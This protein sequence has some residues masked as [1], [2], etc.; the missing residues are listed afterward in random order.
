AYLQTQLLIA[1]KEEAG[2]QLQAE[3]YDLMAAAADLDEIKEVNVN[4]IL[5]ANLQQASTSGTQIDSAPV[6]DSN[7]SAEVH[8]NYDD[9]EIF[10]MF[11]QEEQYTELLEPIPESHQVPQNDND[12]IS[13]DTSVEQGSFIVGTIPSPEINFLI[14]TA[15][16]PASEAAMYSASVADITVVLCLELF[17]SIA[18]PFKTKTPVKFT[19]ILL[20]TALFCMNATSGLVNLIAYIMEPT[21]E[22]NGI[23]EIDMSNHVPNVNSIYNVSNK[24]VKH[25][26]DSTYLWHCHLAHISKKRIEKLKHDELLKS[27]D[28]ESF[29][30]CVSCLSSKMT[31]K[32]FPHR[33]ERATDVLGLIHTDVCRLLRLVSGQ[34]AAARIL[35]MVPTKKVDK[36]PYELWFGKVPILSYLKV[37]GCEV[38]VKRDTPDKLQQRSIKCIFIGYLKETMGYYFYFPP[39]NKIVV[40]GY[41]GFFKKNLVSRSQWEGGRS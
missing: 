18:P 8:E 9:N 36:T 25:N 40:A 12:V 5:M 13:K 20:K 37:W 33:P 38:L 31:R 22:A 1:Q 17:Q 11:T 2:I 14:Q 19:R 35:N 6:Y 3:E 34:E 30:Q 7:G 15:S 27:T 39:E 24:R 4:C 32:S 10:N 28:V 23:Y 21:A 26:L 16:I 29:D 41:A